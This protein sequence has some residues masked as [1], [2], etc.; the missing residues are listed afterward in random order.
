MGSSNYETIRLQISSPFGCYNE[1]EL[2]NDGKGTSVYG[3]FDSERRKVVKRQKGFEL[4]SDSDKRDVNLLIGRMQQRP[5][6]SSGAARICE[7]DFI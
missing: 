5:M 4:L 7:L 1:I 3:L 2:K 6:V